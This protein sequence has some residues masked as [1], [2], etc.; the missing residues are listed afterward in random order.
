MTQEL[1]FEDYFVDT[2]G[3]G[4]EV[5]INLKGQPV[6]I[7]MQNEL[8]LADMA[9]AE[10]AGVKKDVNMETG[11]VSVIGIDEVAAGTALLARCI[12]SWPFT[13]R[14][15]E[16]AGEMVPVTVETVSAL[17]S[18]AFIQL[19]S[20]I[21]RRVAALEAS[22]PPFG[23]PSG[24]ASSPRVK[25]LSILPQATSPSAPPATKS[26]AGRHKR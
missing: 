24:K 25:G 13:Y 15:G 23:K 5:I 9:A 14:D 12:K 3:A 1:F 8:S 17:P 18:E 22:M 21:N 26:T 6:S 10:A 20:V 11:A 7:M 2:D 16:S 4:E 19:Y